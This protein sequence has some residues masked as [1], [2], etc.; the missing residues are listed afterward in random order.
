MIH[1]THGLPD[2]G[3]EEGRALLVGA[4]SGR[5][6]LPSVGHRG[7]LGVLPNDGL[8]GDELT[9]IGEDA[10]CAVAPKRLVQELKA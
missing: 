3:R 10:F 1:G 4:D 9:G 8:D 2:P 6:R 5:F 7:W